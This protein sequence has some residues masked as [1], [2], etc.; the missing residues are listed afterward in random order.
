[1]HR[2]FVALCFLASTGEGH[3]A[4]DTYENGQD[5]FK[6]IRDVEKRGGHVVLPPGTFY[7]DRQYVLP[8]NT[9]LEGSGI[10]RT[11]IQAVN[12][13]EAQT[14]ALCGASHVNRIG[15]IVGDHT[16]LGKF[17][18]TGADNKRPMD[19]IVL[20]GG[21][22]IET[23]GCAFPY[24]AKPHTGLAGQ[25]PNINTGNGDGNGVHN[26][27]I[28]D[29]EFTQF[30]VQNMLFIPP[31]AEGRRVSSDIAIR[32][33]RTNGTWA[34][35]LNIHGAHQN[36]LVEGCS[37]SNTGDDSF[38]AW[39]SGVEKVH[40][41]NITFK[42]N[43]AANPNFNANM[44]E[45]F[46]Q[47]GGRSVN[48]IGNKCTNTTTAMIRFSLAFCGNY[49]GP[50]GPGRGVCYPPDSVSVVSGNTLE[51]STKPI[52]IRDAVTLPKLMKTELLV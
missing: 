22:A 35:G 48:Y 29:I 10:G 11:I 51:H 25:G 6:W 32:N 1:M 15:I 19:N 30:T 16:Y 12:K 28:E 42:D 21:G 34:D 27:I 5:Q 14:D 38:A 41:S 17:T 37:A 31:T 3:N 36:I 46:S 49:S 23:P 18:F 13:T 2:A 50:F 44:R 45:C 7:I 40:M 39:D 4:F 52:I 20:C 43:Y 26:V 9:H 24:C 47:F 33:L 8:A